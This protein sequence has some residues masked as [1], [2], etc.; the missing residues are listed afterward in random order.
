MPH[1]VHLCGYL[2][3]SSSPHC[4]AIIAAT[5][6]KKTQSSENTNF[7]SLHL[8][9]LLFSH[10]YFSV[11]RENHLFPMILHKAP[12]LHITGTLFDPE[13]ITA[14]P[15]YGKS[16][17]VR[18]SETTSKFQ[19]LK[20]R[21]AIHG[22]ESHQNLP[23][24][25]ARGM[26]AA[27]RKLKYHTKPTN[28]RRSTSGE[29]IIEAAGKLFGLY[30]RVA[31][32][33]SLRQTAQFLPWSRLSGKQIHAKVDAGKDRFSLCSVSLWSVVV[34]GTT[35]REAFHKWRKRNLEQLGRGGLIEDGAIEVW[36]TE[37]APR[38]F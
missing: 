1:L 17:S 18:K 3:F 33:V 28:P 36:N 13:S 12:F 9:Y 11:E 19:R 23:G 10:I 14:L 22:C 4:P 2:F 16:S 30:S 26:A 7:T 31:N 37:I 29:G 27:Y 35:H 25:I 8:F 15:H 24:K 38:G 20:N 32:F 21:Y 34:C 6:E 5:T